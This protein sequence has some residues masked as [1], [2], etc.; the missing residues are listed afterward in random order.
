MSHSKVC[1]SHREDINSLLDGDS[2]RPLNVNRTWLE[3][4]KKVTQE[5]CWFR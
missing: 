2:W 3:R 4:V 5:G 1:M